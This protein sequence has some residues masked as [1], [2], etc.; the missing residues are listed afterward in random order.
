MSIEA[1]RAKLPAY[2]KDIGANLTVLASE[3][4]LSGQAKWGCFVASA[5]AIGEPE[6]LKAI[7][8]AAR[9]A[10]LSPEAFKAARTAAAIM[11]MNNVYFRALHLMEA[12]EYRTLPSRL[13]MNRLAHHPGVEIV[14]YELWCVAVSAINACGACLDS[15][16]AELRERGVQPVQVQA[17]LRI[18]A[19]VNAVGQVMRVETAGH[20]QN[21]GV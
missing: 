14:D 17:A 7:N 1:L 15:H 18:A 16:E 10:G 13:R 21:S 12:P 9:E 4:V 19:V 5:C 8:A 3:T 11:A 20:P 2:A 6:T